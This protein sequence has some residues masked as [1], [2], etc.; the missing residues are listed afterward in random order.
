M[1]VN[2][3]NGQKFARRWEVRVSARTFRGVLEDMGNV[4][5]Y[6][7]DGGFLGSSVDV[8][9]AEYVRCSNADSNGIVTQTSHLFDVVRIVGVWLIFGVVVAPGCL[10][11]ELGLMGAAVLHFLSGS[12][13]A[14]TMED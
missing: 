10:G 5:A 9:V 13:F 8:V 1:E 7:V 3:N 4:S 12:G 14:S 6:L 2:I 11:T